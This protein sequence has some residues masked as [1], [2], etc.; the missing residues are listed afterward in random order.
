MLRSFFE[1]RG[2]RVLTATNGP[3]CMELLEQN[4]SIL[5]LDVNMP[6]MDG[7]EVCRRIRNQVSCP[8]LFLTARTEEQDR[9]NG[10]LYGGDD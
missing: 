8:V 6:G 3:E 1:L 2:Y 10:L 4:P 5:L 7:I 9:V